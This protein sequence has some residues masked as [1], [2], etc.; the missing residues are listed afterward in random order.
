MIPPGCCL[1][2]L[3]QITPPS[4]QALGRWGLRLET[5]PLRVLKAP[6]QQ[7]CQKKKKKKRPP[8]GHELRWM[9][10]RGRA[11]RLYQVPYRVSEP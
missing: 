3:G 2:I 11:S 7:E 1:L 9:S 6:E 4:G 5:W 8:K 10:R